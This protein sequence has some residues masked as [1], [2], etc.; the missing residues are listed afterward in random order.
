[1]KR[2]FG[3]KKEAKPAPTM[4]EAVDKLNTRGDSLDEKIRKLDEQLAKHR[5]IIKKTRPGPAQ[6]AAKRRAL[7]V[8]KQKRLYESQR[9]QLYNQQFNVE[10]TTFMMTSMQDT[11]HTVQAMKAAGKEMKGFMKTNDLKIENI[12]KLHDD[13]SDM[14]DYHQ[15]IQDVM[16]TAFGVPEDIDEEELMGELD[17][18]EDDMMTESAQPGGVP[19]Y[20]QD[21]DLPEVPQGQPQQEGA[22]ADE[23]GLPAMPQR[24]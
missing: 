3:A 20:L 18:L 8:L 9:D 21:V 6:E 1:M 11:V 15:E 5:D 13:M 23:F 16:G 17:A 19:A 10:Q 12:E 22:A 2:I 24:T 14:L 7:T 4:D